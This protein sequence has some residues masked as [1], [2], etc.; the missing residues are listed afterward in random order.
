[1]P[2]ILI[3][4]PT[5]SSSDNLSIGR[6]LMPCSPYTVSKSIRYARVD[7]QNYIIQTTMKARAIVQMKNNAILTFAVRP[8]AHNILSF[9]DQ[10]HM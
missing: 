9:E 8:Y 6:F 4:A 1:M 10:S 2:Q 3:I 5:F 7:H